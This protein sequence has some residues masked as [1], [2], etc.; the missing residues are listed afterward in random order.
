MIEFVTILALFCI[1]IIFMLVFQLVVSVITRFGRILWTRRFLFAG[2]LA[3]IAS[4]ISVFALFFSFKS[5]LQ[6]LQKHQKESL[7]FGQLLSGIRTISN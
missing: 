3:V 5:L 7:E 4:L 6:N 1:L 2:N